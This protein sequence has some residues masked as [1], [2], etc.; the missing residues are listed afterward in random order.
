MLRELTDKDIHGLRDAASNLAQEKE[1]VTCEDYISA[2][3]D[4]RQS[5][6]ERRDG[7]D[8]D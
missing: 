7:G 5:S 4:I 1:E 6:H 8:C 2:S 3:K